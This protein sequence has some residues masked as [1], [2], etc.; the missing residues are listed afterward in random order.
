MCVAT[1]PAEE[2]CG[3]YMADNNI[4]TEDKD[5]NVEPGKNGGN[6]HR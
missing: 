5:T 6:Q 2:V 4:Q 3:P 1:E